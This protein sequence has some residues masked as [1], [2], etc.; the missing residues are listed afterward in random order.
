MSSVIRP[1]GPLP[2][3]VYWTRRVLILVVFVVVLSLAWWLLGRVF[4][5]GGGSAQ[6]ANGGTGTS[7]SSSGTSGGS[8]GTSGSGTPGP[9]AGKGH[10]HHAKHSGKHDGHSQIEP[11]GDCRPADVSMA[12][13]VHDAKA[14]KPVPVTLSFASTAAPVCRLAI[15]PSALDLRITSGSN[16]IWSSDSCPDELLAQ[17]LDVARHPAVAYHFTWNGHRSTESCTSPGKV[18]VPGKYDVE[19]A[20]IG[21]NVHTAQFA[22]S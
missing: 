11:T 15:T 13:S 5:G 18:D 14:G 19:A 6:A 22:V 7:A 2:G 8:Q 12:I 10:H 20:L 21:G 3:R 17:Q 4:G 16:V 1:S 9:H